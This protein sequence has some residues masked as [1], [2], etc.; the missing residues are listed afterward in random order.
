MIKLDLGNVLLKPSQKKQ[1][2]SWLRRTLRLGDRVGNFFL[3]LRLSRHGRDVDV[4]ANVRDRAG[5]FNLRARHHTWRA[6]LRRMV[7]QLSS[8]LHEQLRLS[9]A[10]MA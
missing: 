4:R 9:R 3:T 5:T 7:R 6:A 8:R 1:L 2:M 10:A